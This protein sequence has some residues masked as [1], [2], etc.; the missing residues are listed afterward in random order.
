MSG[1]PPAIGRGI[2]LLGTKL[3]KHF[4]WS[5]TRSKMGGSS[6]CIPRGS[7]A[8]TPGSSFELSLILIWILHLGIYI[9]VNFW[10]ENV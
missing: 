8:I 10:Y 6:S 3:L 4:H 9:H 7:G 2:V 5:E 1:T